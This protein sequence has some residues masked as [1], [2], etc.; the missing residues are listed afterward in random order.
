MISQFIGK[1]ACGNKSIEI[2]SNNKTFVC[3]LERPN[4][5]IVFKNSLIVSEVDADTLVG[6]VGVYSPIGDGYSNFA[7]WSSASIP[8][9]LGSGI[10][11]KSDESA[12]F[13]GEYFVRYFVGNSDSQSFTVKI[14]HTQNKEIYKLVWHKDGQ[15]I[16]HGIGFM[17]DD[18][19]A[20]AWGSTDFQFTFD[21]FTFC[22]DDYNALKMRTVH[23]DDTKISNYDF[24]RTL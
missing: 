15:K 16:L 23:W 22:C 11:L 21:M 8:G 2:N 9:S 6:G 10:A 7:L 17:V 13:I 12:E 20:F 5:G 4:I 3:S 19:L 1:W 14:K 24:V 18:S